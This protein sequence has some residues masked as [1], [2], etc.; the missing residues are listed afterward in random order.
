MV[1]CLVEGT[2]DGKL[3]RRKVKPG[4][5]PIV[6]PDH[7]PG[8]ITVVPFQLNQSLLD[9]NRT[10]PDTYSPAPRE[11]AGLLPGDSSGV[12]GGW[13]A[14]CPSFVIGMRSTLVYACSLSFTT[15]LGCPTV[16]PSASTRSPRKD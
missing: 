14:H 2:P 5:W 15:V 12:G 1:R 6:I 9:E 3:C 16:N 13:T 11:G 10:L 7:H 8:Y 4:D